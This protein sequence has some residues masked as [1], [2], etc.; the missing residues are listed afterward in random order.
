MA[1]I[2][3]YAIERDTVLRFRIFLPDVLHLLNE[4]IGRGDYEYLLA[5]FKARDWQEVQRVLGF[6][7]PPKGTCVG[8]LGILTKTKGSPNKR[9]FPGVSIWKNTYNVTF[10]YN[11]KEVRSREKTQVLRNPEVWLRRFISN[12][13]KGKDRIITTDLHTYAALWY[14]QEEKKKSTRK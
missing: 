3:D 14:W 8:V 12:Y 1:F 11:L 10:Q 6:F 13:L 4:D 2:K 7:K 9:W 5:R